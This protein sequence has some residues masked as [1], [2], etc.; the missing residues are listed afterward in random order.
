VTESILNPNFSNRRI[1]LVKLRNLTLFAG[2]LLT[3]SSCTS[4][5]SSLQKDTPTPI[6]RQLEVTISASP[7]INP[8]PSGKASPLPLIVY[9]LKSPGKF[10]SVDYFELKNNGASALSG[11]IVDSTSISIRPGETKTVSLNSG[12]DGTYIGVA[13]GFREI[14]SAKWRA[15]S[16]IGDG[17]NFAV[18]AS[19][20][21][22]SI[23]KR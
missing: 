19:E 20:S 15:Q 14:D 12:I 9:V 16:S 11:D 23:S 8:G 17:I 7:T 10:Q 6:A 2:A 1:F 5:G 18:T 13:A 3:I 21:S 4:S 22:I